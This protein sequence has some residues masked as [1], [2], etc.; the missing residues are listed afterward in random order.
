MPTYITLYRYTPKGVGNIKDGPARLDAA[1]KALEAAGGKMLG[2][3]LTMGRYDLVVISELPDDKTEAKLALTLAS[4]GNVS[5]ET[6]RA[7]NEE[8]FREIAQSL[9]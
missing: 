2:F 8:E 3:Y 9:P 6:L 7:F 5:S 1:K 4:Q